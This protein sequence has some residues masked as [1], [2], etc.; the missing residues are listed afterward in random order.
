MTAS[1]VEALAG[2]LIEQM[3]RA[4]P[5]VSDLR[6]SDQMLFDT[7]RPDLLVEVEFKSSSKRR[8]TDPYTLLFEVKAN[9]QPRWARI[10][11][12]QLTRYVQQA[13]E[14]GS[15]EPM[16]SSL[17]RSYPKHPPPYYESRVTAI[18]TLRATDNSR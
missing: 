1:E 14:R 18:S 5:A 10:S 16:E 13:H 12:D 2:F 17:L 7:A 9:G 6:I 11:A 3:L 8:R 4:I 15:R